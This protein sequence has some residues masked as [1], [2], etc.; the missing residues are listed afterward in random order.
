VIIAAVASGTSVDALD[1]AVVDLR[2]D[3]SGMLQGRL[4]HSRTSPWPPQ[5][6]ELVLASLPPAVTTGAEI[7][8]L[9]QAVGQAAGAA[10]DA[11]L[12]DTGTRA[13]IV[14][15]PGQ[16]IYHDVRDGQC[17]GTLQVGQPAWIAELTGLPVVSDLRARDVAAGGPGAPL[18]STLDA[19]WL[20]TLDG[21][22]GTR[23]ALNLGG[24]ANVTV[25]GSGDRP[26]LAWDTGPANC[27]LDV[28]VAR[29]TGGVQ[30]QD[31]DGRIARAGVVRPDLLARLLAHPHYTA[32]PPVSTGR[33]V[34]SASYLDGIL[35]SVGEVEP[36][37]LL[38]TLTE[39]T[40]ITVANALHPF[41]LVE[42]IASGG[43]TRNPA[44]ME[45]LRARLGDT[46]LVPSGDRGLPADAKEAVLWALLGFLTWHGLPGSTP[47][48][49]SAGPRILGRVTPGDGP[50][51]MP[52]PVAVAPTRLEFRT[53]AVRRAS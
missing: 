16:T 19:L 11:L 38:A 27:L 46:D 26:I 25:V 7:C 43:G 37:D 2:L 33:E 48:T 22:P 29:V 14:V 42:V 17:R 15:S 9:D 40:A 10:V 5:V 28:A 32:K 50:L 4:L 41:D 12:R 49:G 23:A 52:E 1:L 36:A 34:F 30:Q 18:A 51:R 21:V 31:V 8:A 35:A 6:R 3:S 20:T 53:A 24:L 13:E 45:R 39:L 47:A 44:L